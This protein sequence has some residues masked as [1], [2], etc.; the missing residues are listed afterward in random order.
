MPLAERSVHEA[1]HEAVAWALDAERFLGSFNRGERGGFPVETVD[2]VA[3]HIIVWLSERGFRV[4]P[5]HPVMR[6]E[7]PAPPAPTRPDLVLYVDLMSGMVLDEPTY[8]LYQRIMDDEL[9]FEDGGDSDVLNALAAEWCRSLAL[10]EL[11]AGE[12]APPSG[13]V[14]QYGRYGCVL[15]ETASSES[16]TLHDVCLFFYDPNEAGK[17]I[18]ELTGEGSVGFVWSDITDMDVVERISGLHTVSLANLGVELDTDLTQVKR[19]TDVHAALAWG[20]G[21]ANR[22]SGDNASD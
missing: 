8:T 22:L 14:G 9:Q 5:T 7:P 4:V 15:R 2:E 12:S 6:V 17:F 16:A 13:K 10:S 11:L 18:E 21:H 20:R 3:D 19:T 1:S